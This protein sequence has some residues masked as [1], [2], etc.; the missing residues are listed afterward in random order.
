MGSKKKKKKER[1]LWN[2]YPESGQTP[3]QYK[4]PNKIDPYNRL[5]LTMGALDP[6]RLEPLVG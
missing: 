1:G 3:N 2:L 4:N 5:L 6:T